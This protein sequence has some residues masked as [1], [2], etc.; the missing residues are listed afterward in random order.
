MAKGN[1]KGT[2]SSSNLLE[3]IHFNISGPYP[4]SITCYTSF[5]TFIDDYKRYMHLHLI[6]E[7]SKS[8]QTFIDFKT[9]V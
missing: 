3:I 8:L 2:T 9:L 7:N 4:T 6:K 1:K 5:I